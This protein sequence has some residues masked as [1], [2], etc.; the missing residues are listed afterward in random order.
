MRFAARNV[1]IVAIAHALIATTAFAAPDTL[2]TPATSFPETNHVTAAPVPA[3]IDETAKGIVDRWVTATGGR[4]ALLADT[5]LHVKCKQL[6]EGMRG[7]FEYWSAGPGGFMEREEM[8]TLRF[9]AGYDGTAAWRTDLASHKVAPM[10]GKDLE[11]IQSEAWFLAE[12]WAR[13]DQ[14]GGSVRA[15]QHAFTDNRGYVSLEVTPPVG[16]MRTLWFDDA[17]G[18]LYRVTHHRDQYGWDEYVSGWRALAG[19]KRW[20]VSTIGDSSLFFAGFQ[21][22]NVDSVAHER[23]AAGFSAPASILKPVAWLKTRGIARLP[24]R[25]KRGHVWVRASINGAPPGDFILDTGCTM[26]AVDQAFARQIGLESEGTMATS[27]VAGTGIGGWSQLRSVRI[28]GP[29]GDGVEVRDLKAGV[30]E[31]S[32]ELYR[33]EWEDEAGLIGYDF[34]SRFVVD[35]DFDHQVVTLYD[36]ATFHYT[37]KGAAIP[38]TL[39]ACIPTIDV[40]INGGCSGRFIVDVGNA[41]PMFISTEKVDQCG[42]FGGVRKEVQYW[43]GGIGG[44]MPETVCRLDS[45]AIGP[46]GWS[47]PVAGITLHH[48]GQ[49]GS[50]DIQGNIGTSVLD[51]FRCTIDYAHSELWLE[52]GRHF[53]ERDRFSRSGL[54]VTRWEGQVIVAGVVR[55]SPG[56]DAGLKVRDVLK[57]ID[58]RPI[59]RWTPEQ[60]DAVFRDGAA[61]RVVKLTIERELVDQDIELT[62]ADVL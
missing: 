18:L 20:T 38:F 47:Q 39:H 9:R 19:R 53:G 12:Q 40:T 32:D 37:G 31:L 36:P 14:G 1:A 15:G 17:T 50:K 10:E 8:G 30:L 57:A 60:L 7:T 62:L 51:R 28:A 26:S 3:G 29:D 59:D 58:G 33:M 56:A 55:H 61:G 21:R 35:F 48:I 6:S 34:L 16:P 41:T 27:G 13:D 23:P 52:P 49:A 2:V 46:F 25:Y 22:Q 45:V 4:Q 5:L 54:Y 44:S 24:F 42:L 11:A 43:V